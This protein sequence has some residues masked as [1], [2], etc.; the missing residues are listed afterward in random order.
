MLVTLDLEWLREVWW[1]SGDFESAGKVSQSGTTL[2]NFIKR[3]IFD[4]YVILQEKG[5]RFS[6]SVYLL[7]L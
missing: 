2:E 7:P 1:Y 4:M 5:R 3:C 6:I